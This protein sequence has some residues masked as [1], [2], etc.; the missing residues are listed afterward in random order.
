M[1]LAKACFR[2]GMGAEVKIDTE[3][4]ALETLFSEPASTVLVTCA[5]KSVEALVGTIEKDGTLMAQPI[6]KVTADGTLSITVGGENVIRATVSELKQ[7]W[8]TA[9]ESRL[10]TE[11]LA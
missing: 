11:V 8:A 1:A 4:G 9:L 3:K 10:A 6:G 2:K 7:T 5:H